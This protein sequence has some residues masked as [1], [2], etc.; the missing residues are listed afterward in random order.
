MRCAM[1]SGMSSA[2]NFCC[3]PASWANATISAGYWPVN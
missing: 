1:S 3:S 2:E